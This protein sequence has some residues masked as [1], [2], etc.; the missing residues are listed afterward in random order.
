M[1]KIIKLTRFSG[2]DG[3][4]Q[5]AD[6]NIPRC[7]SVIYC[8]TPAE[9]FCY[10]EMIDLFSDGRKG[11]DH[12]HGIIAICVDPT[13]TAIDGMHLISQKTP[14]YIKSSYPFPFNAKKNGFENNLDAILEECWLKTEKE[15]KRV[16]EYCAKRLT[17]P[18][19][20]TG[21]EKTAYLDMF[22]SANNIIQEK[23]KVKIDDNIEQINQ[24]DKDITQWFSEKFGKNKY[25]ETGG[26]SYHFKSWKVMHRINGYKPYYFSV[27]MLFSESK[28]VD[29]LFIEYS[30]LHTAFSLSWPQND[31]ISLILGKVDM[32]WEQF[33]IIMEAISKAHKETR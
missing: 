10:R 27:E 12:L 3:A 19:E 11:V 5:L 14:D 25:G 31:D 8:K 1:A 33:A 18:I 7:D 6:L 32:I 4:K 21:D 16:W 29:S 23:A 2:D 17:F 13:S 30:G 20:V 26:L 9:A 15:L 28:G 24:A 22:V